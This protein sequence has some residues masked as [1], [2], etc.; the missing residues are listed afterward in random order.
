MFCDEEL[1][2][3]TDPK[4]TK[5]ILYSRERINFV[6]S[7]LI[8]LMILAL[9]IVPVYILWKLTRTANFTNATTAVIIGVLLVFT[10]VFSG[11]LSLFT[12]ARRHEVLA[13]AAG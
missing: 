2:R 7:L 4:A 11:V 6:V 13:A 3:K 8:T 10:L 5:I 1:R 12:R 9:L